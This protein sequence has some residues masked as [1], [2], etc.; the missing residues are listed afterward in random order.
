M[1]E[2]RRHDDV[3]IDR[4]SLS[5]TKFLHTSMPVDLRMSLKERMF[6]MDE[7]VGLSGRSPELQL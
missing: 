2:A 4:L 3:F 7:G 1:R 5:F 6:I